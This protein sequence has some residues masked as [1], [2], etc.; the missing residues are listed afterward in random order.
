MNGWSRIDGPGRPLYDPEANSAFVKE[1]RKQLRPEIEV[2]EIDAWIE[3]PVF[4]G[5]LVE[6]LNEMMHR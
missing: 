2:R 6:A 4:A 5:A 3:E 1:L